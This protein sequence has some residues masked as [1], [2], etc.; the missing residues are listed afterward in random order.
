MLE[1][2]APGVRR[3]RHGHC[4]HVSGVE[5]E[6]DKLQQQ[7]KVP[8]PQEKSNVRLCAGRGSIAQPRE[9]SGACA[10]AEEAGRACA[11]AEVAGGPGVGHLGPAPRRSR[12]GPREQSWSD[13]C[14]L[15]RS[16]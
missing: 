1:G 15:H 8:L 11:T 9:Q 12:P 14:V 3:Y 13:P 4:R 5:N 7:N 2:E 6:A 10:A 16:G